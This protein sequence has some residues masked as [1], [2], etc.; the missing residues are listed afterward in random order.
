MHRM[1]YLRETEWRR[2]S[3]NYTESKHCFWL[4]ECW[5]WSSLNFRKTVYFCNLGYQTKRLFL[6]TPCISFF[7]FVL[8]SQI[9]LHGQA[10]DAFSSSFLTVIMMAKLWNPSWSLH[11]LGI[12][13]GRRTG[14]ITVCMKKKT[15]LELILEKRSIHILL[16][17][18]SDSPVSSKGMLAYVISTASMLKIRSSNYHSIFHFLAFTLL[19]VIDCLELWWEDQS[20]PKWLPVSYI[21]WNKIYPHFLIKLEF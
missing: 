5:E 20:R 8:C 1:K 13:I 11:C 21:P 9:S 15:F 10:R 18:I 3:Q 2:A 7:T 6:S 4:G 16:A 17:V 19:T 12:N 14:S